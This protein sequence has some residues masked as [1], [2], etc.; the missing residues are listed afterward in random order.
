MTKVPLAWDGKWRHGCHC[1]KYYNINFIVPKIVNWQLVSTVDNSV[2]ECDETYWYSG[3]SRHTFKIIHTYLRGLWPPGCPVSPAQGLP[4]P[5]LVPLHRSEMALATYIWGALLTGWSFYLEYAILINKAFFIIDNQGSC[6]FSGSTGPGGILIS[7]LPISLCQDRVSCSDSLE[8]APVKQKGGGGRWAFRHGSRSDAV[9]QRRKE[10]LG[11]K[12]LDWMGQAESFS[13]TTRVLVPR[14]CV[15]GGLT[16]RLV[17]PLTLPP[18]CLDTGSHKSWAE[19]SVP[20]LLVKH[21][22]LVDFLH[23]HQPGVR[24]CL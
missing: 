2:H 6:D 24:G 1:I 3:R 17:D 11:R 10:G 9:E 12:R 15:R 19:S 18:L 20:R 22:P 14:P 21:V 8:G 7:S 4:L 13:Q 23:G 5:S 16:A